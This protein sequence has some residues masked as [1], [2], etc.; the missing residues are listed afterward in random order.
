[1]GRLVI[2]WTLIAMAVLGFVVLWA[3]IAFDWPTAQWIVLTGYALLGAGVAVGLV[4]RRR[5]P[6][7]TASALSAS[8]AYSDLELGRS[9]ITHYPRDEASTSQIGYPPP[10]REPRPFAPL[11]P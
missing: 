5:Q 4:W 11:G 2:R 10:E 8:D 6:R 7:S 3:S 1:M 9:P